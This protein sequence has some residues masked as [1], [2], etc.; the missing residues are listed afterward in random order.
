MVI[1]FV[2]LIILYNLLPVNAF[3]ITSYILGSIVY[4]YDYYKDSS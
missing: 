2:V 4:L 1:I 3:Y